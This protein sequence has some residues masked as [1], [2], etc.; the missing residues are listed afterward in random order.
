MENKKVIKIEED[1]LMEMLNKDLKLQIQSHL[2][3]KILLNIELFERKFSL[4]FLTDLSSIFIKKP[5]YLGENIIYEDSIG[6]EIFFIIH[7]KVTVL[8]RRS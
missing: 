8:H 1:E 6:D 7:G 2:T 3:G 4:Q 5:F